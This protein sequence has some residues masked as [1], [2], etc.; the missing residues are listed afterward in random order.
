[1]GIILHAISLFFTI[2]LIG[3]VVYKQIRSIY[4][5]HTALLISVFSV[6]LLII[7]VF[8]WSEGIF[9]MLYLL[10]LVQLELFLTKK[11]NK[12]LILITLVAILLSFQRKTGI[13]IDISVVLTIVFLLKG[14]SFFK[15]LQY[16]TVFFVLAIAPFLL[17]LWTRKS[18]TGKYFTQWETNFSNL[19]ENCI[20]SLEVITTW[21]LPDE[22]HLLFRIIAIL[23]FFSSFWLIYFQSK[24]FKSPEINVFQG[25]LM[26]HLIVY[27][28]AIIFI[29][30]FLQ[31][32]QSFDDRIFAPAYPAFL[33]LF[34]SFI[35][36]F[37]YNLL[38]FPI[39]N[40]RPLRLL[41]IVLLTIWCLYPVSRTIYTVNK[42]HQLGV[43]GYS[44]QYWLKNPL[45]Q[46]LS[47]QP[48]NVL[49]RSN[50]EFAI[51]YH[52]AIAGKSK[53]SHLISSD[54]SN[55]PYLYACFEPCQSQQGEVLINT[56]QG[57]ILYIL[58]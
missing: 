10:L 23:L 53:R 4:I 1:M 49:I 56:K 51:Y 44:H 19:A 50:N 26:I 55:K 18:Q 38:L 57:K 2:Y 3:I 48:E 30:L 17:Y 34:F 40:I 28:L 24:K 39:S 22:I 20:Q 25:L 16:A 12:H 43:G 32:D 31:L 13:I 58:E 54:I 6:P 41:F 29:F 8:V 42:W 27:V 45:I 47:L 15:R 11:N 33:L 14:K 52:M 7:N 37:Y 35:D 21:M 46:F 5:Q 36:K 9:T